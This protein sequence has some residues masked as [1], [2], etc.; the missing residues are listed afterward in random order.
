MKRVPF[1]ALALLAFG[2]ASLK[3]PAGSP[4]DPA[5]LLLVPSNAN[6]ML[7]ISM[8]K[9][10]KTPGFAQ[11]AKSEAVTGALD[12]IAAQTTYDPRKN[13]WQVLVVS[14]GNSSV[15]IARGVFAPLGM[16]PEF[17]K[18]GAVRS[19]YRSQSLISTGGIVLTFMSPSCLAMGSRQSLEWFLD[20]HADRKGGPPKPLLER[21]EMI[22][23]KNQVW[24]TS[25]APAAFIP[26][27]TPAAGG[28]SNIVANL[29]RLLNGVHV[30]TGSMDFSTGLN[31]SLSAG[32]ANSAQAKDSA[33][34]LN[35]FIG[36]A[37]LTAPK[38]QAL[39]NSMKID[40][41]DTTMLVALDVPVDALPK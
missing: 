9:L 13:F 41:A 30:M 3:Q 28:F 6:S 37:K 26:N 7:W 21:A 34:A 27:Q 19:A 36:L 10:V 5:L 15:L 29:P 32:Y 2:C 17:K 11:L 40:L 1:L 16:E 31:L 24:W 38:Q 39:Y 33:A 25:G 23:R 14:N 20:A 12:L 8:E 18:E 35:A 22:D 4:I